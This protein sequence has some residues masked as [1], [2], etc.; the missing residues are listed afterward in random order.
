MAFD[1]SKTHCCT[2]MKLDQ[3]IANREKHSVSSFIRGTQSSDTKETL[4]NERF[5][6][7]FIRGTKAAYSLDTDIIVTSRSKSPKTAKYISRI[8]IS[9]S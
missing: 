6:K 8:I 5:V 1:P 7:S 2:C 9:Y 3:Q 4:L